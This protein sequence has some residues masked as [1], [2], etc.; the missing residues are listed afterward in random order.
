[1]LLISQELTSYIVEWNNFFEKKATGCSFDLGDLYH[2]LAI[3]I[4]DIA[5]LLVHCKV[6]KMLFDLGLM[7]FDLG[8]IYLRSH[9]SDQCELGSMAISGARLRVWVVM[10][11]QDFQTV[12]S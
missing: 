2:L 6:R 1:M 4:A 10:P 9:N 8:L 7:L 12:C 11:L 3:V 5:E